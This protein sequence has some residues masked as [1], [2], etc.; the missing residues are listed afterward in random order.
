MPAE[1]AQHGKATDYPFQVSLT[2]RV[3]R[4]GRAMRVDSVMDCMWGLRSELQVLPPCEDV[5]S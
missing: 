5:G 4:E 3:V 2:L 1:E